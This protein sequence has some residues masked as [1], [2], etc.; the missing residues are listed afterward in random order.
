MLLAHAFLA[1][2]FEYRI[3]ILPE[4][5]GSKLQAGRVLGLH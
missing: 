2:E 1:Y 4:T 3:Q 5:D